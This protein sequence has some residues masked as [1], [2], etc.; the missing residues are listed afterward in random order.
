MRAPRLTPVVDLHCDL[1]AYLAEVEGAH[2]EDRAA[3]GCALPHLCEGGVALQVMAVCDLDPESC[4]SA[5]RQVEHFHRLHEQRPET[6]FHVRAAHDLDEALAMDRLGILAAI[7]GMSSVCTESEPLA[8]GLRRFEEIAARLAPLAYVGLT[9]GHENRFGGGNTSG[10]GL[11]A[12]GRALLDALAGRGIA[13]DL[14]HASDALA[15]DALAHIDAGSL[16]L[17][18]LAS[19]SNLRAVWDRPRNL[20][21]ALAREIVERGGLVGISLLRAMLHDDEPAALAHHVRH[22]L[23]LGGERA[24]GLGADFFCTAQI[25][26]PSRAPFYFPEHATA[27]CYPAI[28]DELR[29]CC[30]VETLAFRNTAA[31]LARL[32]EC[33]G[34]SRAQDA[35]GA[36]S[37]GKARNGP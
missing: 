11:K 36:G 14:S 6:V 37:W 31:F 3:I 35:E 23:D 13:L 15:H 32:L 24:L 8:D 1:L 10:A 25:A 26:D 30:E 5:W 12:D 2:P 27:A 16:S 20:P 34:R 7:E 17:P 33:S 28:L 21:D 22:L 19:H 4:D 18:V 9:H 29:T